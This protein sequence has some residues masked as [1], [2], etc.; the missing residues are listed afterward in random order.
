M[1]VD[2]L[3]IPG[4]EMDNETLTIPHPRMRERR[5]VLEPLAEIA[6]DWMLDGEPIESRTAALR[7]RAADQKCERDDSAT[8]RFA[9]LRAR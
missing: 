9:E 6:P 3:L 5:F 7:Q 1:D 2:V 4:V 8:R